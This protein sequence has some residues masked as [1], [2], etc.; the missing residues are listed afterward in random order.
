MTEALVFSLLATFGISLLSFVGIFFAFRT[1][2]PTTELRM[3]SFAA[4]VLLTT[5]LIDLLPEAIEQTSTPEAVGA[6]ALV[7]IVGFYLFERLLHGRVE[8]HDHESHMHHH[9]ASRYFI[10]VGDGLHNFVDGVAIASAFLVDPALGVAATIAVAAHELPHEIGDYAILIRGGYS[11]AKALLYNF[12][13]GL[14]ALLGAVA[15][16]SFESVAVDNLGLLLGLVAGMFVYIA[17]VNLLPELQHHKG[18]GRFVNTAPFLVGVFSILLLTQVWFPHE[19]AETDDHDPAGTSQEAT[20]PADDHA[21][22]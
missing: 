6:A 14:T 12:V 3:V 22:E 16:F 17:A 18:T 13:S 20:G 21:G 19:H 5:A 4:G 2:A 9:T 7:G 8:H 1:L 15:V 10:L 11:R